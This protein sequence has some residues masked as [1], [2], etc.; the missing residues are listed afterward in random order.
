MNGIMKDENKKDI[1]NFY[2]RFAAESGLEIEQEAEDKFIIRFNGKPII[3][4]ANWDSI[5][6]FIS[7]FQKGREHEPGM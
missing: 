1:F 7:G 3:Y 6:P 5:F 2:K 4:V